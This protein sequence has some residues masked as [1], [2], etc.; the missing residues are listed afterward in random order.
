MTN[1]ELQCKTC[2]MLVT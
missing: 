1:E 2:P